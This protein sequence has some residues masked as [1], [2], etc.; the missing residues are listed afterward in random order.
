MYAILTPMSQMDGDILSQLQMQDV[1][2][3]D[4]KTRSPQKMGV[5]NARMS[6]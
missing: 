2:M 5:Q 4:Q 1:H 3:T 6:H